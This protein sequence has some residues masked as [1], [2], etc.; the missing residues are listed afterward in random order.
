MS[1]N[2]C[3]ATFTL[4]HDEETLRL[5][6]FPFKLIL[7]VCLTSESLKTTLKIVNTGNSVFEFQALLHTY[8]RVD[9]IIRCALLGLQGSRFIDQVDGRIVEQPI[10]GDL[11]LG[12]REIDLVFTKAP[13]MNDI[14]LNPQRITIETDE[15]SPQVVVWNPWVEKSRRLPDFPDDDYHQMVCV[16]PGLARTFEHLQ[17]GDSWVTSQTLKVLNND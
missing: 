6:P 14:V 9:D 5:W 7:G 3:E 8:L 4:L 17:P 13:G 10:D 16:E 15:S 2:S 1:D 12:G 11:K